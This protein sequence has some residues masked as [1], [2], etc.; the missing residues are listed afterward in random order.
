MALKQFGEPDGFDVVFECTGAETCVQMSIH[1]SPA[2][3][4][5]P[6]TLLTN[7]LRPVLRRLPSQEA[8]S[9]SWAWVPET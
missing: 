6:Q 4:L 7:S 3:L 5:F 8:K 1:V 2:F 9:C